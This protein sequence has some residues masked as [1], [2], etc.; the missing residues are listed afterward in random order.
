MV[1]GWKELRIASNGGSVNAV[2]VN[3]PIFIIIRR[4]FSEAATDHSY[5]ITYCTC[6]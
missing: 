6:H 3:I 2:L 1:G 4:N 5:D